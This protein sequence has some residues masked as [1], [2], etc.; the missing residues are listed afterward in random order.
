MLR[1]GPGL[2]LK[3]CSDLR[4]AAS[5]LT[6]G[7]VAAPT[8]CDV[9]RIGGWIIQMIVLIKLPNLALNKHVTDDDAGFADE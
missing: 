6:G 2:P 7:G 8:H 5:F 1:P 4:S 3:R 9:Y